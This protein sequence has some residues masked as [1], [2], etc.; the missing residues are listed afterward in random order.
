[1]SSLSPP[2]PLDFRNVRDGEEIVIRN[3]IAKMERTFLSIGKTIGKYKVIE[4]IDRGGMAVVYKALQLDLER[5]V[6]LKVIPATVSINPRFLDRFLAEA[7]AVSKLHHPNIVAIHEISTE[8]SIYFIAMDYIPGKNLFYYLNEVKPKL[9]DVLDIVVQL[10]DALGYAH[11]QRIIHRDLKL[12]NVIMQDDANP[13]LIDFGLAKALENDRS[14]ITRTGELVGSPAYMA[15]ERI[16][17]GTVDSR[18]DICSLGIMLYEMLTFKNPYLDQRSIHQT[19][20]NVIE[21]SPI[22][23][24]KLV[25]WLPS[26]VDAITLKAMHPDPSRRYQTME[27]FK[28]DIERYQKGEYVLAQ[29]PSLFTRARHFLRKYWPHV[30]IASLVVVFTSL[31]GLTYYIQ[32][33]KGK[34]HWQVLLQ[35][36]FSSKE[37]GAMWSESGTASPGEGAWRAG[38]NTLAYIGG[39]RSWI[40]FERPLTRDVRIE[41][42]VMARGDNLRDLGI[43]LYGEVPSK[44]YMFH[45]YRGPNAEHGVTMPGGSVL[46]Q[47]YSPLEFPASRSHHIEIERRERQV[48]FRVDGVL[49]SRL[50]DFFPPLGRGHQNMGFFATVE[51]CAFDNLRIYQ[52]AIPE[53]PA[54]TLVADRF[55]ERGDY[56]AAL[57]EYLNLAIDYTAGDI[58]RGIE[59]RVP[60]CMI[61]LGRHTD[62][63]N[64][65]NRGPLIRFGTDPAQAEAAYLMAVANSRLGRT[66]ATDSLYRLVCGRFPHTTVSQAAA[67]ALAESTHRMM[68]EGVDEQLLARLDTLVSLYPRH[69]AL[70]SS[71]HLQAVDELVATGR[72][73]RARELGGRLQKLYSHDE[74][75]AARMQ[76]KAAYLELCK[77][78]Q[79]RAVEMLNRCVATH[80]YSAGVWDA[81][82]LLASV[83]E[84]DLAF[85]DA[86][87]IYHKIYR[88]C[89]HT[90]QDAWMARVRMGRI[91]DKAAHEESSESIF[92]D[93]VD[94]PHPFVIP[95]ALAQLHLKEISETRFTDLWHSY[96]PD[97]WFFLY[98]L[99]R[100]AI[101]KGEKV[102]AEIYLQQLLQYLEQSTWEYLQVYRM[103]TELERM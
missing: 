98:H 59:L 66:A 101:L 103:V 84:H 68:A 31:M 72:I 61:R 35:E 44:G 6:A 79:K 56:G 1:M 39:P 63:L 4:E 36:R 15:P 40:R 49:V 80:K 37:L 85:K 82:M 29:P 81:W 86:V 11:R 73:D 14:S 57:E 52:L 21:A 22:P 90:H 24:R 47:D 102:V 99:A 20:M 93:V 89:P 88:E 78:E 55:W 5:E 77:R 53:S 46:K 19:T 32:S 95:R 8:N 45:L 70:F 28:D 9:V 16:L 76:T 26:E 65:L 91:A 38:D 7:H 13:V 54:P 3:T 2:T 23:P 10:A 33:E 27:E 94:S 41:C 97:D 67:L 42:D 34:S 17:G 87:T 69:L 60:D 48:T 62:A 12:N 96:Y 75:L 25:P 100:K 51:P 43:F 74:E 71:L 83:Y 18:S 64:R 92:Q 58:A 50:W 30:A